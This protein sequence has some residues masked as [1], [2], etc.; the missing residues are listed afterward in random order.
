LGENGEKEISIGSLVR[1]RVRNVESYLGIVTERI[2]H[3]KTVTV[4]YNV[5]LME[6]ETSILM[7]AHELEVLSE[8]KA[9]T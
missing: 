1:I 9:S 8:G 6:L 4:S 3:H 5:F 7:F 2:F